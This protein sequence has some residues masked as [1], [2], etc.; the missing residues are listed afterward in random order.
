MVPDTSFPFTRKVIDSLHI[1]AMVLADEARSYFDRA[2]LADKPTISAQ[3]R[4]IFSCE[5]LKVTTRLMHSVAWLLAQRATEAEDPAPRTP[6]RLGKASGTN[7][8]T[9][10]TL[11]FDARHIIEMSADLYER[12]SRLD[13]QM[14]S[15]ALA[16]ASPAHA[17]LKELEQAF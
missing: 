1:E 8:Q 17:L 16:A 14:R 3:A 15:G 2:G 12:I 6:T 9:L 13:N 7:L 10:E 4:V 11:P 5:A